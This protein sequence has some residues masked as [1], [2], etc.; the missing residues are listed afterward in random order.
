MTGLACSDELK[1]KLEAQGIR[2]AVMTAELY[3]TGKNRERV[4]DVTEALDDPAKTGELGLLVFDIFSLNQEDWQKPYAETALKLKTL[5]N[6]GKLIRPVTIETIDDSTGI[7]P[8]FDRMVTQGGAEGLVIRSADSPL[9]YKV[10]PLYTL[11]AVIAGFTE[12][13]QENQGRV[14]TLL[15]AF[16]DGEHYRIGVRIGA[17][18][19]DAFKKSL[20]EKLSAMQVESRYIDTD[21]E[22][23]AFR[24][25]RPEIV[26]EFFC[27]D[28]ITENA[29]GQI[30]YNPVVKFTDN[31]YQPAGSLPGAQ[32]IF[33]IFSRIRDDKHNS[34]EETGFD[35]ITRCVEVEATGTLRENLP[36]SKIILREVW[37]KEAKDKMMIQK[38]VLW[39]TGKSIL[40]PGYPAFVFHYTDYSTGRKDMLNR[41]IRVSSDRDQILRIFEEY[42]AE[43]IKKGWEKVK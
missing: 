5:L 31:T 38:F 33:P 19:D 13:S 30:V 24:M 36:V 3:R 6:G 34:P 29:R 7:A 28:F 41:E 11:D 15:L 12:G 26:A 27:N 2:E 42:K 37:Q 1:E 25:V 14:R 21:R 8:V 40:A 17:P 9:V 23:T 32:P 16:R 10:K 4:F 39:E 20:F 43:N 35:Q 22:G 18:A